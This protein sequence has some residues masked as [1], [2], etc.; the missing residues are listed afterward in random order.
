METGWVASR[1]SERLI[2][3]CSASQGRINAVPGRTLILPC[4]AGEVP[5]RD[6]GGKEPPE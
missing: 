5:R 1:S 2:P 4:E 3:V 6:G